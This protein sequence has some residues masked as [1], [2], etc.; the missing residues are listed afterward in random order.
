MWFVDLVFRWLHIFP[1]IAMVGGVIF[2]RLAYAPSLTV[3]PDEQREALQESVRKRWA[4]MVM[5]GSGLLLISGFYNIYWVMKRFHVEPWYNGIFL[6]KFLL[7]MGI[8]FIASLLTGRSERAAG[9]RKNMKFW[10]N[11]NLVLAV[12]VVCIAGAMKLD[13]HRPKTPDVPVVETPEK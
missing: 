8:F 9:I 3:L 7:A 12:I 6:V 11:I 10:L 2:M 13:P 4:I 1:A 5:L